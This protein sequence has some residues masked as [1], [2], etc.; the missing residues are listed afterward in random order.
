LIVQEAN[1]SGK[2][3]VRSGVYGERG[4]GCAGDLVAPFA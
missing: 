2:V 4:N 3:I 1:G